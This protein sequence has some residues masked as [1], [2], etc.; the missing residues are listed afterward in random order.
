VPLPRRCIEFVS[1][2]LVSG[3]ASRRP[4]L[5][6]LLHFDGAG[7]SSEVLLFWRVAIITPQNEFINKI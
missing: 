4:C 1:C 7:R 6:L 3:C 2:F 5:S